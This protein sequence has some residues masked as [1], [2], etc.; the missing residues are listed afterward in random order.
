MNRIHPHIAILTLL[1]FVGCVPPDS[2]TQQTERKPEN[3]S[4]DTT[5]PVNVPTDKIL[6]AKCVGV[7]CGDV[8]DILT[9]DK[10]QLRVIL[11]SIIAPEL[12]QPFGTKAKDYLSDLILD[13]EIE[14]AVSYTGM[15]NIKVVFIAIGSTKVNAAMIEQ[16]LAWHHVY[17]PASDRALY[18]N[19]EALSRIELDARS[20][21]RGLWSD[22][23]PIPPL[24]WRGLSKEER[25]KLR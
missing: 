9:P 7:Y 22:A 8:V 2:T 6:H 16:G 13:K 4:Q 14:Y 23:R 10:K 1:A 3:D 25:D 15:W 21:K 24:D 12:D 19:N 11:A 20:D 17:H 18:L 5:P